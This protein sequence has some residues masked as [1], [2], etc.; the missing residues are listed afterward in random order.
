MYK[1]YE[2]TNER[3]KVGSSTLYR[4]KSLIDFGDVKAGDL[5]GFIAYE[6]NLSHNGKC[7]VFGNAKVYE[8]AWGI[9]RCLG[10]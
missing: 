2:L 8:N 4:I 1:K 3:I 7:W 6:K 10:M 5:G 9:W